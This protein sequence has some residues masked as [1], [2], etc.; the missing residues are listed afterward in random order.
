MQRSKEMCQIQTTSRPEYFHTSQLPGD[1]APNPDSSKVALIST[2]NPASPQAPPTPPP[3]ARHPSLAICIPGSR[4]PRTYHVFNGTPAVG[5]PAAA[6]AAGSSS[7]GPAGGSAHEV[8]VVREQDP[9][10]EPYSRHGSSRRGSG[11]GSHGGYGAG[12]GSVP[13]SLLGQCASHSSS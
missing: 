3:P 2:L 5:T 7:G 1:C 8:F 10:D 11:V 12:G 13:R 4:A 9:D 6:A